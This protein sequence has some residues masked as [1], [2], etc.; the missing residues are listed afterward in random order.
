MFEN[1]K[2]ADILTVPLRQEHVLQATPACPAKCAVACCLVDEWELT[3]DNSIR[4]R[5]TDDGD[6]GITDRANGLRHYFV[7]DAP[8]RDKIALFDHE[9]VM[10][11][12]NVVVTLMYCGSKPWALQTST[13]KRKIQINTNRNVRKVEG[14]HKEYASR[15]AKWRNYFPS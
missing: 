15:V 6:I 3:R 1:L 12:K 11:T 5:S 8:T 7:V 10:N 13:P 9:G 2:P 4:V 14:R